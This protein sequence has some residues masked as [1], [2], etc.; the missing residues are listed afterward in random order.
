MVTTY[1]SFA[2]TPNIITYQGKL[3]HQGSDVS[4][5]RTI[6]ARLYANAEG[7]EKVWEGTYKTYITDG[8]FAVTLGAGKYP[9][10]APTK[11]DK[12]LWVGITVD[13]VE[14]RPL[15]QL[16]SSPYALNVADKSI[17]KAKLADEVLF[18]TIGGQNQQAVGTTVL[19]GGNLYDRAPGVEYIGSNSSTT[20]SKQVW[21]KTDDVTAL[22]LSHST[23]TSGTPNIIG[24]YSGNVIDS[25]YK[26]S[27]ISG[28]GESGS[29]NTILND[30][31][32]IGGGRLNTIGNVSLTHV[33]QVIGGGETNTA[34]G[35]LSFIGAGEG[36]TT[37][38]DAEHSAIVGGHSN[39]VRKAGSFIGG[40]YENHAY[41]LYTVIGG[42]S[43]NVIT[44]LSEN[45]AILGGALN[46][47]DAYYSAIGGGD[48]NKI[49]AGGGSMPKWTTIGGGLQNEIF[50]SDYYSTIG[51]GYSNY[52]DKSG[53]S[54]I[55]GGYD[56]YVN[57]GHFSVI[58][59]GIN[60]TVE[61]SYNTLVGGKGNY[62]ESNLISTAHPFERNK[63]SFLG[64]GLNNR[65]VK[66]PDH[67]EDTLIGIVLVGGYDNKA[68]EEG[69]FVGG[70][71]KNF[72]KE[73]FSII[74]GG[75]QNEANLDYATVLG[76]KENIAGADYSIIAG[77]ISNEIVTYS[78]ASSILGGEDNRISGS[79]SVLSNGK[80]NIIEALY[81]F[82]GS[83][84]ANYIINLVQETFSSIVGGQQNS[85]YSKW[86]FIGGGGNNTASG[87]LS[88]IG[89]GGGLSSTTLG[90]ITNASASAI[91]AGIG[92]VADGTTQT[93]MGHFNKFLGNPSVDYSLL[94]GE[95][96]LLIIGN[97]IDN[98]RR[99][100]AFEVSENGHSI[101][102]HNNTLNTNPA[103]KG[104][105]YIDNTTVSWGHVLGNG[106]VLSGF[107]AT[108]IFAVP[109][110]YTV[111]VNYRDPYTNAIVPI[112]NGSAITATLIDNGTSG[113]P[114]CGFIT[115]TPIVFNALT[116]NTFTVRTWKNN[117]DCDPDPRDFMFQVVGRP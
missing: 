43:S 65:I 20:G 50:S 58:V 98:A 73:E 63:Y 102:Y 37:F 105:R 92:L 117:T 91:P 76:G 57:Q 56:N 71:A 27:V 61:D 86:S 109:N 87:N 70:G 69:T 4:G 38:N 46:N 17:T 111:T 28:G 3:T 90:N 35:N 88:F 52:I 82:I 29:V 115:V 9:L 77:G 78:D 99:T 94:L 84:K 67:D 14:L 101:V 41:S 72:A 81:S 114:H 11:L 5:E 55:S 30:F 18:G 93:I 49:G 89:A 31:G 108:V 26:G 100:N 106:V 25:A 68:A 103:I 96:R 40:G 15:T 23:A 8:I 60:N 54:V 75:T 21:F 32:F 53:S 42:G 45:S 48:R 12:Q 13:G 110:I 62:I 97:G 22:R 47:I 24:G 83:G 66:D 2:Q 85:I 80:G 39:E 33:G 107:A 95:D 6:T 19:L 44:G 112:I 34:I 116:G 74:L 7:T 79:H 16:T 1:N 51:G 113:D 59:G 36:N 104:A 64:G 10:P